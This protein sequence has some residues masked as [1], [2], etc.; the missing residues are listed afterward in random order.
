MTRWYARHLLY[1]CF[2]GQQ[3]RSH[4]DS[5]L[6]ADVA[7]TKQFCGNCG[8]ATGAPRDPK[9]LDLGQA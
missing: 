5:F 7:V 1:T 6:L 3:W 9:D 8:A 2:L 4:P